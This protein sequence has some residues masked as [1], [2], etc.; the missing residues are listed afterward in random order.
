LYG[1]KWSVQKTKTLVVGEEGV[2]KRT[3][4]DVGP[5]GF[6]TKTPRTP[7]YTNLVNLGALGALVAEN[8]CLINTLFTHYQNIAKHDYPYD[9]ADAN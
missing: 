5:G 4:G 9:L 7:R 6:A 1:G 8:R 3:K 2:E